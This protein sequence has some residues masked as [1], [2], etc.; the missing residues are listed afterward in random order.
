[1]TITVGGD[2]EVCMRLLP[3]VFDITIIYTDCQTASR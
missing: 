3:I 2:E 1:M